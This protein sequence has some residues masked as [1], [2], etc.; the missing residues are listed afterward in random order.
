VN[1]GTVRALAGEFVGSAL[2]TAVVVGSG[3]AAQH[4]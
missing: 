1:P 3:I 2:L 4:G